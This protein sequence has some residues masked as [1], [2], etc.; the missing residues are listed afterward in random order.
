MSAINA[1]IT[2][3]KADAA[4]KALVVAR[5]YRQHLPRDPT[6]PSLTL[7]RVSRLNTPT[8]GNTSRVVQ[9]SCWAET[10]YGGEALAEVVVD[11]LHGYS[12]QAV[13]TETIIRIIQ[14]A[15]SSIYDP[16]SQIYHTPVDVR[17]TTR[18]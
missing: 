13:G 4:V 3:L 14:V 17:I 5:V 1:I 6:F 11:A 7:H 2:L 16:E 8:G 15:E 10:D 18:S 12:L 9:I